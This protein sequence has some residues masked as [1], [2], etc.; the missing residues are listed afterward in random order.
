MN[1]AQC[2]T[3]SPCGSHCES[4]DVGCPSSP[5]GPCKG[6]T[7]YSGSPFNFACYNVDIYSAESVPEGTKCWTTER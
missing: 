7:E 6:G 4:G 5:F 2:Q 1:D 3:S